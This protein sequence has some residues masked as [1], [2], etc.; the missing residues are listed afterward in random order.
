MGIGEEGGLELKGVIYGGGTGSTTD[1]LV[2]IAP[3]TGSSS[4][5][6]G[7]PVLLGVLG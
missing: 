5:T 3:E 4:A 2:P 7:L 6:A 1:V